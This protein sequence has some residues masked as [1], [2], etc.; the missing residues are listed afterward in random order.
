MRFRKE[1]D[2]PTRPPTFADRLRAC[3]QGKA[4]SQYALAKRSGL[5]KQALSRLELGQRDPTWTTV[6]LL[7]A[8][9]GVSC[10]AFTVPVE[11]PVVVPA[12]PGRPPRAEA[13]PA[14]RR[15]GPRTRKSK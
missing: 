5:T 3:R 15:P 7:A 12:R 4:L 10:E 2:M 8:A 11:L 13:R 9:L 14:A 6:Q 1:N